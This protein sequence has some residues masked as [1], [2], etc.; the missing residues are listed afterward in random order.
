V[1]PKRIKHDY[2]SEVELSSLL[3]REKNKKIGKNLPL[4]YNSRINEY[5]TMHTKLNRIK[6]E[7]NSKKYFQKNALKNKIRDRII[8]LSERTNI[9]DASHERFGEVILLMIKHILTKPNF[10]G[11][12]YATDFYSDA[13]YKIFTYLHNFDH[14]LI[15]ERTNNRVNAFAYISQI[16]HNSIVFIIKK[17]NNENK[18]INNV[19]DSKICDLGIDITNHKK[20]AHLSHAGDVYGFKKQKVIE[21]FLNE[22]N[23]LFDEVTNI[24]KTLGDKIAYLYYPESYKISIEEF[25]K[26]KPFLNN[27]NVLS[28]KHYKK[29]RSQYAL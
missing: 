9:D 24:R 7:K 18:K 25:Y 16:I 1:K 23:S 14:T 20:E 19:V 5:I 28:M 6:Y 12:T 2:T 17:K 29:Q 3:I 8:F 15:S 10:S 21:F 27:I 26:I 13:I 4:T 11:Y 22:N